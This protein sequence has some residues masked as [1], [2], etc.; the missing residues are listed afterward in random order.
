MHICLQKNLVAMLAL[1]VGCVPG[2]ASAAC[3]SLDGMKA[4]LSGKAESVSED[5][6]HDVKDPTGLFKVGCE[7]NTFAAQVRSG[8]ATINLNGTQ[9]VIEFPYSGGYNRD[10]FDVP[11]IKTASEQRNVSGNFKLTATKPFVGNMSNISF[12]ASN[13]G[14]VN[15]PGHDSNRYALAAARQI[16]ATSCG[17]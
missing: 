14:E 15:D 6:R 4:A 13:L 17:F 9:L 7:G 11:C 3:D 12:G 5:K 8:E 1:Y 16:V 2:I 10:K